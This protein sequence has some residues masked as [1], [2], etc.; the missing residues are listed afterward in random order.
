MKIYIFHIFSSVQRPNDR[1]RRGVEGRRISGYTTGGWFLKRLFRFK[2]VVG[3]LPYNNSEPPRKKYFVRVFVVTRS[4]HHSFAD[5]IEKLKPSSEAKKQKRDRGGGGVII[6]ASDPE[7]LPKSAPKHTVARVSK[8]RIAFKY[9][10]NILIS[11]SVRRHRGRIARTF[12]GSC[13]G[14]PRDITLL[15]NASAAHPRRG[16]NRGIT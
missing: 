4:F 9:D 11:E 3:G 8:L 12:S 5:F 2:I 13:C 15:T 16:M 1:R 7:T 10:D 14:R 6:R